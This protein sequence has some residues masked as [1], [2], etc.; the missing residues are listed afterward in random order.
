MIWKNIYTCSKFFNRRVSC[1][2]DK[3]KQLR[4]L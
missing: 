1:E 4:D 3:T 2:G